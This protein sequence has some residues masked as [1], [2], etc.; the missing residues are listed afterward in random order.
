MCISNEFVREFPF[1][2]EP[3]KRCNRLLFMVHMWKVRFNERRWWKRKKKQ[4]SRKR[5]WR[6]FF[7]ANRIV[8]R[9]HW[10][11]IS[12][13]S[14]HYGREAD[15]EREKGVSFGVAEWQPKPHLQIH[16]WWHG[17]RDEERKKMLFCLPARE[18]NSNRQCVQTNTKCTHTWILDTEIIDVCWLE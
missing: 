1:S 9:K 4:K 14:H 13:S 18:Q 16:W 2:I 12:L 15:R 7:M 10:S 11:G 3:N 8:R 6:T 17:N 5:E